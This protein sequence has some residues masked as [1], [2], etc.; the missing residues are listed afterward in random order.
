MADA[1]DDHER[2]A[3][4]LV[5]LAE[6]AAQSDLVEAI[7]LLDEALAIAQETGNLSLERAILLD[8]GRMWLASNYS[9]KGWTALVRALEM[10][11]EQKDPELEAEILVEMGRHSVE[12]R[13]LEDGVHLLNRALELSRKLESISLTAKVLF[14]LARANTLLGNYADAEVQ[15]AEALRISRAQGLVQLEV[16][17]LDEMAEIRRSLGDLDAAEEAQ[18]QARIVR[19]RIGDLETP[20]GPPNSSSPTPSSAARQDLSM[21]DDDPKEASEKPQP[22]LA[23]RAGTVRADGIGDPVAQVLRQAELSK[24]IDSD[25]ELLLT[26]AVSML[27]DKRSETQVLSSSTVF[28]AAVEWG[29]SPDSQIEAPSEIRNLASAVT[30][31]QEAYEAL[32]V[33]V[34]RGRPLHFSLDPQDMGAPK[35]TISDNLLRAFRQAQRTDERSVSARGLIRETLRI[36][37]SPDGEPSRLINR[38]H[39]LGLKPEGLE[40]TLAGEVGEPSSGAASAFGIT[41]TGMSDRVRAALG[42]A[43]G[44]AAYAGEDVDSRHVLFGLM[45]ETAGVEGNSVS[46]EIRDALVRGLPQT[47]RA[48]LLPSVLVKDLGGKIAGHAAIA[49]EEQWSEDGRRLISDARLVAQSTSDREVVSSRHLLGAMFATTD[50]AVWGW[51]SDIGIDA[52]RL[53]RITLDMQKRFPVSGDRPEAWLELLASPPEPISISG[54]MSDR[55]AFGQAVSD[56]LGVETEVEALSALVMA[57]EVTPPMSIGLFGDWG[58]GKTYFMSLMHQRIRAISE[59][60]RRANQ[61]GV[62]TAFCP[63]VVQIHFNAWHFADTN[64]WASIVTRVFGELA[65][66]L[67]GADPT[68]RPDEYEKALTVLIQEMERAKTVVESA[69]AERNEAARRVHELTMELEQLDEDIA[70]KAAIAPSIGDLATSVLREDPGIGISLEGASATLGIDEVPDTASDL[71]STVARAQSFPGRVRGLVNWVAGS[72][73]ASQHVRPRR[74]AAL[75][76]VVAMTLGVPLLVAWLLRSWSGETGVAF[77]GFAATLFVNAVTWIRSGLKTVNGALGSLE[78]ARDRL[79]GAMTHE[80]RRQRQLIASDLAEKQQ[81]RDA[82]SRRLLEAK[83][84]LDEAEASA[85]SFDLDTFL[86]E[87]I[88]QR[89]SST[90]YRDKLG[91]ISYIREDFEKLDRLLRRTG[92]T[93]SKLGHVD[94]I[95][96]Y[97]DDLDRCTSRRVVEVLQAVHLLLSFELFVVVVAVDPRWLLHSLE[98]EYT[99]FGTSD[100]SHWRTTPHNYLEKIFQIPLTLRP[101]EREGFASLIHDLT[102]S[103]TGLPQPKSGPAQTGGPADTPG[104]EAAPNSGQPNG[105]VTTA[106]APVLAGRETSEGS[107]TLAAGDRQSSARDSVAR[108]RHADVRDGEREPARMASIDLAPRYLEI[109]STERVFISQLG[110]L[111]ATPRGAK[112]LVNTYRL[113][114]ATIS[115]EQMDLLE[116]G[117]FEAVLLMLGMQS[118]YP[119]EAAAVFRELT[120]TEEVSWWAFVEH[121]KPVPHSGGALPSRS[122]NAMV[123]DMDESSAANWL[124]LHGAMQR[125]RLTEEDIKPFVRHWSSV[126]RFGFTTGRAVITHSGP[127]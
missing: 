79:I 116:S 38:L 23:S 10:S 63:N 101:M 120:S 73:T 113:I 78:A 127:R 112:R 94:R 102:A 114:K 77:L 32:V 46:T 66:Q 12:R 24:P 109:T 14:Y 34:F 42:Y 37:A 27:A 48:E 81:S 52:A 119:D 67:S 39:R 44:Q 8:L 45:L 2:S 61:E 126:A 20:A 25:L 7:G 92:T 29:R 86:F 30:A 56:R 13:D 91:I 71:W 118:G 122:R 31:N 19:Q 53:R 99:A 26:G 124:E 21:P 83:S 95:V 108:S 50:F 36:A 17:I 54:Y 100:R 41:A 98:H 9:N 80:L 76:G 11:R 96:L 47:E 49:S 68:E 15:L 115:P 75:A 35:Y 123:P 58:M 111:V 69:Q 33:S 82:A 125:T 70:A 103:G 1:R 51:L 106:A 74:A 60:A 4:E 87:W 22:V 65:S 93:D 62:P 5:R 88:L 64:L 89:S 90:A 3:E 16:S 104:T 110:E 28:L 40:A 43:S 117:D 84:E 55:V 72:P 57:S 59:R 85:Q 107:L 121:W 97:I 6:R 18:N 105:S